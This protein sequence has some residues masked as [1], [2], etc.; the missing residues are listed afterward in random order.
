MLVGGVLAPPPQGTPLQYADTTDVDQLQR[1]EHWG[2][3]SE[4]VHVM[5]YR[6]GGDKQAHPQEYLSQI[7]GVPDHAPQP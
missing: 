2:Q 7:V 6:G 3:Q 4:V 1:N 5:E